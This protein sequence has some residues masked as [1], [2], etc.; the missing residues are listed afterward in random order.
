MSQCLAYG[1][2]GS[3]VRP[4]S[5]K[6][7]TFTFRASESLEAIFL[8]H[9]IEQLDAAAGSVKIS[10]RKA[11]L[12]GL[13]QP[14]QMRM[15][16]TTVP[17]HEDASSTQR[18][19]EAIRRL[20]AD[21]MAKPD[22][23]SPGQAELT[24]GNLPRL[25]VVTGMLDHLPGAVVQLRRCCVGGL[26]CCLLVAQCAPPRRRPNCLLRHPHVRHALPR[27]RHRTP[28]HQDQPSMDQWSGRKNESHHQRGNRPA[29]PL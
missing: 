7:A 13:D 17:E 5:A 14:V 28:V 21:P 16:V 6:P 10:Q 22:G 15:G 19:L 18:M 8:Q 26:R 20:K 9:A 27:K 25:A 11:A 24:R 4:A 29:R 2:C 12:L 3:N 1:G 23:R